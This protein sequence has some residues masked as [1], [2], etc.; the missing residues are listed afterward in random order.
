MNVNANDPAVFMRGEQRSALC[1]PL[2]HNLLERILVPTP[3]L[4]PIPTWSNYDL[5]DEV[6]RQ[7]SSL[8]NGL[9]QPA[10]NSKET[11]PSSLS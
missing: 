6:C 1:L 5:V 7:V 10:R 9:S 3:D 8:N 11:V 2:L 4:M